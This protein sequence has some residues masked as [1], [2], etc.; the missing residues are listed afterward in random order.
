MRS[1]SGVRIFLA[2]VAACVVLALSL[3]AHNGASGAATSPVSTRPSVAPSFRSQ[4]GPGAEQIT[5]PPP[6]FTNFQM[7][8]P[9]EVRETAP[10]YA[11]E[12]QVAIAHDTNTK[13][14]KQIIWQ[15]TQF[16]TIAP[17]GLSNGDC[18]TYALTKRHDLRL[19]GIPDGAL[20]LAVVSMPHL[21]ELHMILEL[22]TIDG[23]YVLDSL[24]NGSGDTFYRAVAMPASYKVL[25]YQAWGRPKHW[26]AP[27]VLTSQY[28]AGA[29]RNSY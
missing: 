9:D 26:L 28:G 7:R 22:Q 25:K 16:W 29:E 10:A 17:D 2:A 8:Y 24:A 21:Q 11:T 18:K 1:L 20:R 12:A 23:I 6:G 14:N 13:I 27:A 19:N 5:M 15:E 4:P 3:V